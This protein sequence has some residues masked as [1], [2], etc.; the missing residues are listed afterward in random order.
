MT[1]VVLEPL[2]FRR[3]VGKATYPVE[4]WDQPSKL[5]MGIAAVAVAIVVSWTGPVSN[6]FLV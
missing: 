3:P 6:V 2:I 4:H 1:P 5:P